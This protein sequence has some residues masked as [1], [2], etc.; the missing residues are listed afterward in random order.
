MGTDYMKI[1]GE[2]EGMSLYVDHL[3]KQQDAMIAMLRDMVA[4]HDKQAVRRLAQYMAG[5][6]AQIGADVEFLQPNAGD[7][8]RASR[9]LTE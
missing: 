1:D 8:L 7:H 9:L 6:F 2:N 4:S 3:L 5:R